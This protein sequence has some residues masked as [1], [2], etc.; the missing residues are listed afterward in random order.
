MKKTVTIDLTAVV[1][2]LLNNSKNVQCV[3]IVSTED[4]IAS[5]INTS[6]LNVVLILKNI[7][8]TSFAKV[9][10]HVKKSK[11]QVTKI[12]KTRQKTFNSNFY[13]FFIHI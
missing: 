3:Y 4:L 12:I 6:D 10:P 1:C 13:K 11:K 7:I 5:M 2:E 8:E 9:K